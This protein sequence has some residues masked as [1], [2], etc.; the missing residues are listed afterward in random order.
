[1]QNKIIKFIRLFVPSDNRRK[2]SADWANSVIEMF[3]RGYCYEFA[4]AL[5]IT[6]GKEYHGRI[7]G[8]S[9]M[10]LYKIHNEKRWIKWKQYI[11][12]DINDLDFHH[13]M[14]YISNDEVYDIRGKFRLEAFERR[15]LCLFSKSSK[16]KFLS[17]LKELSLQ[18]FK[19]KYLGDIYDDLKIIWMCT[20][21][22]LKKIDH[23]LIQLQ[24]RS[25]HESIQNQR[26]H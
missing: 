10:G 4:K 22:D 14:F 7:I 11:L 24:R 1:M 18:E 19:I 17:D 13:F 3:T 12:E 21:R 23:D 2:E 6:F 9:N 5:K 26:K 20:E 8:I 16:H 15:V 25:P